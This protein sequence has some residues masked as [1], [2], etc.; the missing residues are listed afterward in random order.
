MKEQYR[1]VGEAEHHV[2]GQGGYAPPPDF[3]KLPGLRES[4]NSANPAATKPAAETPSPASPPA[5]TEASAAVAA[6]PVSAAPTPA[7]QNRTALHTEANLDSAPKP[8]AKPSPPLLITDPTDADPSEPAVSAPVRKSEP[9][10]DEFGQP[11]QAAKPK[12][13]AANQQQYQ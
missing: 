7:R 10:L 4:A 1:Q 2:F 11:K 8:K 5:K 6:A 9:A 13:K 12:A 3:T